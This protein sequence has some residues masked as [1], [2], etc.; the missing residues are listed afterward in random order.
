MISVTPSVAKKIETPPPEVTWAL[1]SGAVQTGFRKIDGKTLYVYADPILRDD[2][3]AGALAV[4]LDASDLKVAEWERW[5]FNGI[6]FLVLAA[7]LALIALLVVRISLTQPLAKM[8]RWSVPEATRPE[9]TERCRSIVRWCSI[10]NRPY[11]VLMGES[12]ALMVQLPLW[13]STHTHFVREC[14]S[15][16][17]TGVGSGSV[18][19]NVIDAKGVNAVLRRARVGA[20]RG[21]S[22]HHRCGRGGGLRHLDRARE[23]PRVP[24]AGT[25]EQR[26][27]HDPQAGELTA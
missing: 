3:A 7:V 13:G 14:E 26:D 8:A 20:R 9:A 15:W 6:R 27:Q 12:K 16:E 5:R 11:R 21:R 23:R 17:W 22:G 19:E 18:D 24:E 10:S 1:T 25:T 4:F 2:K